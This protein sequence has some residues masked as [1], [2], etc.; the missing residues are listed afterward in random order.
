MLKWQA[1]FAE[2]LIQWDVH[3]PTLAEYDELLAQDGKKGEKENMTRTVY[4]AIVHVQLQEPA[5]ALLCGL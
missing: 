3:V 4:D 1:L 2:M 5:H